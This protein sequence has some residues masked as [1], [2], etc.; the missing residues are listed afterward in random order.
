MLKSIYFKVG[1]YTLLYLIT[2][3]LIFTVVFVFVEISDTGSYSAE[4]LQR[5]VIDSSVIALFPTFTPLIFTYLFKKKRP[6]K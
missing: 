5:D 3:A 2:A 4:R 1:I 6:E